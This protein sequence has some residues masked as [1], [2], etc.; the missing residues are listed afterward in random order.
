MN[1]PALWIVLDFFI[2]IKSLALGSSPGSL[3]TGTGGM[4]YGRTGGAG[5]HEGSVGMNGLGM[6]DIS[7]FRCGFAFTGAN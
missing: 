1:L 7:A 6:N 5:M 2:G 3:C 4:A